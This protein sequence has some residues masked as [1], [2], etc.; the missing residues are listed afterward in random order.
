MAKNKLFKAF[1]TVLALL[2]LTASFAVQA[3]APPGVTTA[4]YK[5]TYTAKLRNAAGVAITTTQSVRFSLW[6]D[7]DFDGSEIDGLGNIIPAAAGFTGWQETHNITPNAEGIFTVELG[8]ISNFPNFT[9]S[10]EKY[11]Q[12]DVKPVASPLTSFEV[13]DPDG[14]IASAVDR[15]PFNSTPYTIN[16]DT[17]DNRDAGSAPGNLPILN[18]GGLLDFSILPGGVN[19][20]N[21]ILDFDNTIETAGTGSIILQFG[22]TL[23]K[24]L[25]YDLSMLYFNFNDNLNVTGN[26][27]VTGGLTVGGVPVGPY[28]QSTVYEPQYADAVIS[29][30]GGNNR[31][32]LEIFYVDVDGVPGNDNHNYYEWTTLQPTLQ[33][34][35][36]VIRY[37]IPEG[38]SNWS[39]TPVQFDY[40]TLTANAADNNINIY[41]E[42]TAGNP[43]ALTGASNL[44][45]TGWSTANVTFGGAP[46]FTPGQSMTIKVDLASTNVGSAFAGKLKLNFNGA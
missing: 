13:L 10:V 8:T 24:I 2:A 42:D 7:A 30:P 20:E 41:I 5:L 29:Q 19:Q 32:K 44:V 28:N 18:G 43:V 27:S 9:T 36:L 15:K 17:V 37:R 31:G 14:N 4:P 21:Y 22:N 33:N 46:V 23:G 40:K 1:L 39:A 25:E 35:H 12:V 3:A 34:I 38:F 16:A 11:L 6:S 26:L 45:S